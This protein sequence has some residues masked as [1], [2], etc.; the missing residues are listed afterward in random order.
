MLYLCHTQRDEG[1]N[2]VAKRTSSLQLVTMQSGDKG[3]MLA[4][5]PTAVQRRPGK[6]A[7]RQCS[8]T[9]RGSL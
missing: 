2:L 5:R 6:T 3:L 1:R 7:G 8:A 9:N 4:G